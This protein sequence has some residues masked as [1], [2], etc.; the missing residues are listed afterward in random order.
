MRPAGRQQ[1]CL[2]LPAVHPLSQR[3][4]ITR[5]FGAVA[6]KRENSPRGTAQSILTRGTVPERKGPT[7]HGQLGF[8]TVAT[9]LA[10][11]VL[12]RRPVRVPRQTVLD[13]DYPFFWSGRPGNRFSAPSDNDD[14]SRQSLDA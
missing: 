8:E 12:D 10:I 11:D 9:I 2:R 13:S 1:W 5:T 3:A 4:T 6:D 14:E 7:D